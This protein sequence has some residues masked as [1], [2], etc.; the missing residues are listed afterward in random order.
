MNV[1]IEDNIDFYKELNNIF[2]KYISL[3]INY[4]K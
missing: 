3:K 4:K 2:L 1:I